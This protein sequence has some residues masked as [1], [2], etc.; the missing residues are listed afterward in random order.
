MIW[1]SSL[2][3]LSSYFFLLIMPKW[4]HLETTSYR[5]L[6][7]AQV[8]CN[9]LEQLH[10]HP[11]AH[12]SISCS[13]RK[14]NAYGI[15]LLQSGFHYVQPNWGYNSQ[16]KRNSAPTFKSLTLK[17][18]GPS[19]TSHLLTW[20]TDQQNKGE[21]RNLEKGAMQREEPPAQRHK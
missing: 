17:S 14:I 19:V 3:F 9:S 4:G 10:Q 5:E 6:E 11:P 7:G 20:K 16:Q 2:T 21:N 12:P 18:K 8:T 13:V 1:N 15:V